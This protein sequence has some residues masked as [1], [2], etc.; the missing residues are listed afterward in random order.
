MGKKTRFHNSDASV[1]T[2]HQ[3]KRVVIV[4]LP[5]VFSTKIQYYEEDCL[6]LQ[7]Q[8]LRTAICTV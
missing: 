3:A 7:F 4:I 1:S 6:I 5:V 2:K 8:Y